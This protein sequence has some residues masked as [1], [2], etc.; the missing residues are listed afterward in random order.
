MQLMKRIF[1]LSLLSDVVEGRVPVASVGG[2]P[3]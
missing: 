1:L 2:L 3:W